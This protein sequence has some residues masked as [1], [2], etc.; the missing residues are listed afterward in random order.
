MKASKLTKKAMSGLV[1]LARYINAPIALKYGTSGLRICSFSSRGQKGS[2]FTSSDLTTIGLVKECALSLLSTFSLYN[3]IDGQKHHFPNAQSVT[4]DKI[5]SFQ[6][7]S[8]QI[9]IL[10]YQLF[11]K[12]LLEFR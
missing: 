1:L 7:L 3:S 9:L 12:A 11:W 8:F 2:L 10:N 6:D 4:Q 5:L